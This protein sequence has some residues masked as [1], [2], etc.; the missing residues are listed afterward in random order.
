[1]KNNVFEYPY[2]LKWGRLSEDPPLDLSGIDFS[3]MNS[4][5]LFAIK[6]N[7]RDQFHLL[8][9]DKEWEEIIKEKRG[10]NG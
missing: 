5:E 3:N 1:M 8:S 4:G 6:N 10:K 7:G 2:I 9:S